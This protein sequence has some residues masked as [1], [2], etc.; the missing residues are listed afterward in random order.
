MV[1]IGWSAA[2][3]CLGALFALFPLAAQAAPLPDAVKAEQ[4]RRMLLAPGSWLMSF[5]ASPPEYFTRDAVLTFE[6]RQPAVVVR[7][8]IPVLNMSCEREVTI[9]ADGIV[10]DGC[11]DRGITLRWTPDDP[12]FAFRGQ[13][14]ARWYAVRPN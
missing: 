10:F 2:A 12:V 6:L 3:V 11:A 1:H 13:N 4:I 7:I 8:A 5:P 9:T 14:A